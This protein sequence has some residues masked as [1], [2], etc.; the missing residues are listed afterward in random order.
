MME[1]HFDKL[2]NILCVCFNRMF[3][4]DY[5]QLYYPEDYMCADIIT[6]IRG[7]SSSNS[8]LE[9]TVNVVSSAYYQSY[10]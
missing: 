1:M 9:H 7:C 10:M 3:L 5:M 2:T 4:S 8:D 6:D